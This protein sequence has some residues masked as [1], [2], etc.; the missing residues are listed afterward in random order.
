MTR[1]RAARL[2]EPEADGNLYLPEYLLTRW[3]QQG[4]A[5]ARLEGPGRVI[6]TINGRRYEYE[7]VRLAPKV[8]ARR[9]SFLQVVLTPLPEESPS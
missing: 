4:K 3:E 2:P 7:G 6:Y 1:A 9:R 5:A 8:K